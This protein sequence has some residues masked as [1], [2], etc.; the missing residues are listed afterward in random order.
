MECEFYYILKDCK[1]GIQDEKPVKSEICDVWSLFVDFLYVFL[2]HSSR[3]GALSSS[4]KCSSTKAT[5][6]IPKEEILNN[7]NFL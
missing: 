5:A 2:K 7:A 3:W 1:E 6:L 4:E